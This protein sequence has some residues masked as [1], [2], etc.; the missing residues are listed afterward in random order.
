[1]TGFEAIPETPLLAGI[2]GEDWPEILNVGTRVHLG[3]GEALFLQDEPTNDL[4][5]VLSGFVRV[6]VRARSGETD[7]AQLGPGSIVGEMSFLLGGG[8]SASVRTSEASELLR[9]SN[10]AFQQILDGRSKVAFQVLYN[11]ARTMAARLRAADSLVKEISLRPGQSGA[12][13]P[14]LVDLRRAFYTGTG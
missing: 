2:P 12:E 4:Y 7:L 14:D 1:M 5:V 10:A 6:S 3:K 13:E 11:I 8:R 9:I